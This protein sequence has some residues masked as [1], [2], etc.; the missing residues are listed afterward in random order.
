[1]VQLNVPESKKLAEVLAEA[2]KTKE[3]TAFP[4][5][6]QLVVANLSRDD[7]IKAGR[8]IFFSAEQ[9][10]TVTEALSD[11]QFKKRLLTA[12]GVDSGD[13]TLTP[14]S[15]TGGY[16]VSL[17]VE[18][19]RAAGLYNPQMQSEGHSA[20]QQGDQHYPSDEFQMLPSSQVQAR[21]VQ[22]GNEVIHPKHN[23]HP[24]GDGYKKA[25]EEFA[26]REEAK[27]EHGFTNPPQMG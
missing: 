24:A 13:L 1:M 26:A 21:G 15:L 4:A 10:D 3:W 20:R 25:N 11:H 17:G 19:A 27:K 23:H 12:L 5:N 2:L 16:K 22:H 8:K 14:D 18:Q 6:N 9:T 7:L